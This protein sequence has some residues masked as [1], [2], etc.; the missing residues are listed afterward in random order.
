MS[1]G[2]AITAAFAY[3]VASSPQ[4]AHT[5]LFS[6]MRWVVLGA[7]LVYMMV[8]ARRIP[9]MTKD[10]ALMHFSIYA[11]LVGVS[12]S[13]VFFLYTSVS[14]VRTFL[15]ASGMFASTSMYGYLTKRDLT[16]VGSLARMA[17]FGI[18]LATVINFFFPSEKISLLVSCVG[19]VAFTLLTAYDTQKIKE[20]YHY[21]GGNVENAPGIAVFG[22]LTLY[23][24]FLNLFLFLLRLLGQRRND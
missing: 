2:L 22:A 24:D 17:V 10:R 23:L 11:S 1:L 21:M 16:Q 6:P 14:I 19:V 8:F 4:L 15:I 20:L 13:S 12:L 5:L 3:V 9:Y 18:I 7:P